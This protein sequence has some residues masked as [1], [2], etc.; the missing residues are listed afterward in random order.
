MTEKQDDSTK[1]SATPEKPPILMVKFSDRMQAG[2]GEICGEV[3][4]V[5]KCEDNT[6]FVFR[7]EDVETIMEAYL[8]HAMPGEEETLQ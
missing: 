7:L 8:Q 3:C 1:N 4:L 2:V 5:M 6:T